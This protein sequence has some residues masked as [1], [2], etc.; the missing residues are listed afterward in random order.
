MQR[1]DPRAFLWDAKTGADNILQFTGGRSLDAYRADPMLRSAVER[2]FEIIGE[3]LNQLT[4]VAPDIAARVPNA[5]Q[6]I[7]FRNLLIHGYSRVN[8]STV[9]R[10]VEHDL[11]GFREVVAR[12]LS[13]L[14]ETSF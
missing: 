1:R 5:R 13:E 10:T 8:D 7:A 12:L 6:I 14:G 2:Q 3:A 9:W 4:K 11:P